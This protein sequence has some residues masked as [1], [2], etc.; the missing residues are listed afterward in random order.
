MNGMSP[1]APPGK[2]KASE[3]ASRAWPLAG[4]FFDHLDAGAAVLRDLT[5]VGVLHQPL[6]SSGRMPV[7]AMNST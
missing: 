2:G 1:P 7:L 3:S 5:D 6:A 4:I